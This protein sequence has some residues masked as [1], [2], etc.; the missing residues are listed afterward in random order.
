MMIP[1]HAGRA[2]LPADTTSISGGLA[3]AHRAFGRRG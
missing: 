1:S 2:W 3:R